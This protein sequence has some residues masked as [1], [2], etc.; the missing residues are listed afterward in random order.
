[1]NS[2]QIF[3]RKNQFKQTELFGAKI[4]SKN[5]DNDQNELKVSFFCDEDENKDKFDNEKI[6]NQDQNEDDE[7]DNNTNLDGSFQMLKNIEKFQNYNQLNQVI[8]SVQKIQQQKQN[9]QKSK[10]MIIPNQ[11]SNLAINDFLYQQNKQVSYGQN[12][13][14]IQNQ[15]DQNQMYN[16][17][18]NLIDNNDF[19][20]NSKGCD[21]IRNNNNSQNQIQ[22]QNYNQS[23]NKISNKKSIQQIEILPTQEG[24]SSESTYKNVDIQYQKQQQQQFL[25]E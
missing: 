9:I 13:K 19:N 3:S 11:T 8:N 16:F 12:E 17:N 10:T 21:L 4:A 1:M 14:K 18:D 15:Q 24:N 20:K 23:Q 6:I 7:N 5:L 25:L 22:I 2:S